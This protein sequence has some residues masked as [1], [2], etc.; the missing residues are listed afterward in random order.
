MALVHMIDGAKSALAALAT[1]AVTGLPAWFTHRAVAAEAAPLWAYVP[2]ATLA[3]LGLIMTA[4][5]LRKASSGVSPGR[6]R[7]R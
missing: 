7:R 5:F 2:A 6:S 1:V 4:A 3:V